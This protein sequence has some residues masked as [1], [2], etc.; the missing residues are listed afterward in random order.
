M[1]S[2]HDRI[3][4]AVD[5][6][7]YHRGQLTPAEM[8]A[9]EK[10]ALEDPLLAEAMDGYAFLNNP[11]SADLDDLNSRLQ[12]RINTT[13]KETPVV[14]IA[15]GGSKRTRSWWR[16]AAAILLIG[17]LGVVIYQFGFDTHRTSDIAQNNQENTQPADT[18]QKEVAAD[19]NKIPITPTDSLVQPALNNAGKDMHMPLAD[20]SV[21]IPVSRPAADGPTAPAEQAANPQRVEEVIRQ[22]TQTK[23]LN[24]GLAAKQRSGEADKAK[25][26]T[27]NYSFKKQ[28]DSQ[29]LND[30]IAPYLYDVATNNTRRMG[31]SNPVRYRAPDYNIFRGKVVDENQQALPFANITNTRDQVG[32]YA[33][34]NG[35]FVLIS[36]DTAMDVQ[37]RSIGFTNRNYRLVQQAPGNMV[38][39]AED[40]TLQTR[41]LDTTYRVAN[42][43]RMNRLQHEEPEP[44][45]GWQ[46]YD[47]YVANNLRM[48]DQYQP[49]TPAAP[50]VELSFQV[51]KM[52]QPINIRIVRSLCKECD[53]EAIRLI[54]EGP[55][56]KP[57]QKGRRTKVVLSF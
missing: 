46:M 51:D 30:S 41:V 7:K 25:S 33:D 32:T 15:G 14:P 17:T 56:W 36:E 26:L 28:D 12:N 42:L 47:T 43:A 19:S 38:E 50:T 10:A 11:V 55:R 2:F 9:M 44:V 52:G 31:N 34:A 13:A 48:P 57:T 6:E 8:H 20:T 35:N 29:A 3:Y 5:I 22:N 53:E 4:S 18:A 21:S 16:A 49:K 27:E 37:V 23:E 39:M 40:Q 24:R 54:R 1:S 45:D